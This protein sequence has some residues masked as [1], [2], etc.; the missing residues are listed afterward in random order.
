M[1]RSSNIENHQFRS[2]LAFVEEGHT[3]HWET[4]GEINAGE[5]RVSVSIQAPELT[6][7]YIRRRLGAEVA[8]DRLWLSFTQQ[9]EDEKVI[10]LGQTEVDGLKVFHRRLSPE[11]INLDRGK[12]DFQLNV[13]SHALE[14]D[15]CSTIRF[16]DLQFH[17]YLRVEI[18]QPPHGFH[19][20][21]PVSGL[22][23]FS[24]PFRMDFLRTWKEFG[25]KES[26]HTIS[27]WMPIW[28]VLTA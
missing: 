22:R 7:P 27:N 26:W 10:L 2:Q 4:E 14:L 28:P 24:T 11:R 18:A 19:T 3:Q 16:N 1:C 9:K 15:S 8:F 17:P 25:W 21:T 23:S 5:R 20:S 13:E 6:V 12:L